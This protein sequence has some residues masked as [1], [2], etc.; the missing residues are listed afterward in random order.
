MH[1]R[2]TALATALAM[3]ASLSFG[4][5]CGGTSTESGSDMDGGADVGL[6]LEGGFGSSACG[7]CVATA[8]Q[9]EIRSCNSDPDCST[10]L[11]CVDI[12]P[13]TAAGGPDPACIATCPKGSS[14]AGM[15]AEAQLDSCRLSGAG[16]MCPACGIDGGGQ[17]NPIV[18]QT[19]TQMTD[20]TPCFTCEDNFCC[21]TYAACH[22]DPDCVAMV[23]CLKD[24]EN[25]TADDAGAP[26]GGAPDGGTCDAIC[27]QAHPTGVAEWAPRE[28]CL[29]ANCTVQCENP[30]MPPLSA[31]LACQYKSCLDEFANLNAT[32]DGYLLGA[33][34]DAC[35]GGANTCNEACLAQYPDEM[36]AVDALTTCVLA[37]CPSCN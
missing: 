14:S 15:L 13:S 37:N 10:Y 34:I 33:C 8:C 1:G 12:C 9:T 25:G 36:A 7:Q 28:T 26:A 3:I 2:D 17:P 5:G 20:Q 21:N 32:T 4:S 16:A 27:A 31:C 23:T 22:A 30:P 6:A 24:C 11:G 29:L 19:C 35:P 18:H